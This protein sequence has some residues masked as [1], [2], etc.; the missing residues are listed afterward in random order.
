[1]VG[2]MAHLDQKLLEG[3]N[4]AGFRTNMGLMGTGIGGLAGLPNK[5]ITQ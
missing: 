5:S 2:Y 1:M 4:K 3:L